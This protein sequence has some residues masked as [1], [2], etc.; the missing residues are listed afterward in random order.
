MLFLFMPLLRMSSRN[1]KKL[2]S[3]VYVF[4]FFPPATFGQSSKLGSLFQMERLVGIG[5]RGDVVKYP[6]LSV[7]KD[8]LFLR[9]RNK[10]AGNG[11][12]SLPNGTNVGFDGEAPETVLMAFY[13][14]HL[15]PKL[16]ILLT[17]P[18]RRGRGRG[19]KSKE[20]FRHY[21]ER[22]RHVIFA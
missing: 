15:P 8:C 6:L 7:V 11:C 1:Y 10:M 14:P 2:H 16:S 13:G 20:Y 5:F 21:T 12:S 18:Q 3:R 19:R 9:E 17:R 22:G 4:S